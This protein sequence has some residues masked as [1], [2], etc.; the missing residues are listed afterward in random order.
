M[1]LSYEDQVPSDDLDDVVVFSILRLCIFVASG[2]V[3]T[4][5]PWPLLR[6]KRR[7]EVIHTV[8]RCSIAVVV[9]AEVRPSSAL[10]SIS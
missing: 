6:S 5:T 9:S 2:A 7:G 3:T 1:S 4:L 8:S 10:G